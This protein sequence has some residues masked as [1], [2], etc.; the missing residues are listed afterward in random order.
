[1][2]NLSQLLPQDSVQRSIRDKAGP[3]FQ[4]YAQEAG[5]D[6]VLSHLRAAWQKAG[7]APRGL[8]VVVVKADLAQTTDQQWVRWA[9]GRM[10]NDLGGYS[11]NIQDDP[12]FGPLLKGQQPDFKMT[13]CVALM[14]LPG[15][16]V[17]PVISAR[18]FVT[19]PR[20]GQV[21]FSLLKAFPVMTAAKSAATDARQLGQAQTFLRNLLGSDL[22]PTGEIGSLVVREGLMGTG[23]NAPLY[24]A[25]YGHTRLDGAGYYVGTFSDYN[26]HSVGIALQSGLDGFV[27]PNLVYYGVG[28]GEGGEKLILIRHYVDSEN[29]RVRDRVMNQLPK[30]I[31]GLIPS[32]EFAADPNKYLDQAKEALVSGG[33]SLVNGVKPRLIEWGLTNGSVLRPFQ[34]L[35]PNSRMMRCAVAAVSCYAFVKDQVDLFLRPKQRPIV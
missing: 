19:D 22:G 17:T 21:P 6:P 35:R 9:Y 3:L 27:D 16:G 7:D 30:M 31:R 12:G 26:K 10:V 24:Q 25:L 29:P 33:R 13:T 2:I 4:R 23:A 18:S 1:M 34:S 15:H 32:A 5:R 28:P 11:P 8:P 14:D 20:K